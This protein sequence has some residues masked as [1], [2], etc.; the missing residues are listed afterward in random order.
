M[1]SGVRQSSRSSRSNTVF[2]GGLRGLRFRSIV[3]RP[4]SFR[5]PA[6]RNYR[7]CVDYI[8]RRRLSSVSPE[9]IRT[10][11]EIVTKSYEIQADVQALEL[12]QELIF[13]ILII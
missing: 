5:P 8:S 11:P 10:S 9:N 2:H 13:I 12:F 6:V 3:P 7:S 1:S 4:V